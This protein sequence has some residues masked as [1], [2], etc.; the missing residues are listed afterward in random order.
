MDMPDVHHIAIYG[1][2]IAAKVQGRAAYGRYLHARIACS[3]RY[4][5]EPI[6]F[7]IHTFSLAVTW[8][9]CHFR[10]PAALNITTLCT[11]L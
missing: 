7:S 11:G 3:N 2:L 10:E 9:L 8:L 6:F 1:D 5:K 4:R